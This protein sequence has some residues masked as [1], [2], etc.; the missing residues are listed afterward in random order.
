MSV[1]VDRKNLQNKPPICIQSLKTPPSKIGTPKRKKKNKRIKLRRT[2]V[3]MSS[4]VQLDNENNNNNRYSN[5]NSRE[6]LHRNFCAETSQSNSFIR[7][8]YQP[9]RSTDSESSASTTRLPKLPSKCSTPTPSLTSQSSRTIDGTPRSSVGCRLPVTLPANLQP[10]AHERRRKLPILAAI[11]P[12]NEKSERDRFIRANFN[13]NPFFIYKFPADA[14]A[15][16]RFGKPSDK[17]MNIAIMIM[18]NAM[19]KYGS[20]ELFEE[21]TGGKILERSSIMALIQRYL[22]R[23]ELEREIIVNLSED[24]LSRGSMTRSKGKPMLNVRVINLREYWVEGLLRHEI[25][26]HYLRSYNNKYQEWYNWK[27][28]KDLGMKPAN[29]TEEGLASL[30]SVLL[31][32]DPCLWRICLLY[33]VA[34][35]SAFLSLKEL[36]HDLGQYVSDP[37][38]RWDY[39]MRAKRGQT[40]TSQAGGFCKDQVYLE[41]A[42]Q[43]LKNRKMI[44]FHLLVQM[45]KIDWEDIRKVD[46]LANL[47]ETKVPCFMQDLPAYHKYLDKICESNGLTEEVLDSV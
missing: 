18:E 29:P 27:I 5:T 20:Y 30:H 37:I 21:Q 38:A 39:C 45:G 8:L 34:Y 28:R 12:E 1:L 9:M 14:E 2:C 3:S 16:E 11:K 19:N 44:D 22:K 26:T 33:Y 42:L 32:K 23:E 41:G 25:G 7:H 40:D 4:I 13:Y 17:Y 35:K 10:G 24:L 47:D 31:R 15:L 43:I 36:F 6:S 46:L